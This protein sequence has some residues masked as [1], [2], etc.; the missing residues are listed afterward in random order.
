MG[1]RPAILK[2]RKVVTNKTQVSWIVI[3]PQQLRKQED[4]SADGRTYH[5]SQAVA[6]A[7]CT[8][9]ESDLRN[10]SDKARGLTDAQK[11]EA[12]EAFERLSAV[13]G[14]NLRAA[15]D[16]YLAHLE[17]M[18]RS[19]TLDHLGE[20]ILR[21]RLSNAGKGSEEK[22]LA[23]MKQRWE[24]FA[25]DFPGRM[26]SSITPTEVHDWLMGFRKVS[27]EPISLQTRH[28]YKTVLHT[29][30]EF[31]KARVRRWVAENPVAEI[32]LPMPRSRRVY[33][34][35]IPMVRQLL[36]TADAKMVPYFAL[37][38]FAG[39]RPDHA[40]EIDWEHIHLGRLVIE[41]PVGTDKTDPERIIPIQPCLKAWLE[42]AP[43]GDRQGKVF[44]SKKLFR[45]ATR[46]VLDPWKQDCL[47][48]DFATYRFATVQ[49]FG[50]VAAEM[51]NSEAVIKA[52]Y[53]RHVEPDEAE[54]YW[55]IFPQ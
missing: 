36:E 50:Q 46:A 28:N 33:L 29:V 12:Q 15:I 24:R 25:R 34:L 16:L 7:Y 8:R 27:G 49:S 47:R 13:P 44:Y 3:V 4:C 35:P 9:L 54:A 45:K 14:A 31:A 55:S 19:V 38:A 1:R 43:A 10:Y 23:D 2:P 30:F 48:H 32:E 37:C 39:L 22:T 51:G 6:Q 40:K 26:A 42:K 53:W 18:N 17:Q 52:R 20:T 5:P 21:E 11:I 41:V